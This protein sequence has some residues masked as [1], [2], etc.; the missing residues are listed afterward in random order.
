MLWQVRTPF[1]SP[2]EKLAPINFLEDVMSND[3]QDSLNRLE[4]LTGAPLLEY[5]DALL[6]ELCTLTGSR[7]SYVAAMNLNEDVLTMIGWSKTAMNNCALTQRPIVY[8]LEQTGL[9]GDAVRQRKP[10][11]TNDYAHA[12]SPT[13]RGYPKGHVEVLRHLNVPIFEDDRIVLVVGV[14]NK[15]DEYTMQDAYNVEDLMN[16]IWQSFRR[17]L[18][19]GAW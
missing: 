11:I 1:H 19:D 14:G 17:T 6:D 18:W 15:E 2:T 7:L 12:A 8:D 9:W 13:K 5:R 4:A 3:L 10:V 16:A